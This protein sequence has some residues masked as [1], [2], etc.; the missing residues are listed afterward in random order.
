MSIPDPKVLLEHE[1]RALLTRLDAVQPLAL[2]ETMV[3]AANVS[4][5][6]QSAMERGLAD[7]SRHVRSMVHAFLGWLSG[8]QGQRASAAQAQ[9]RFC[10]LRLRFNAVLAHFD[11]FSDG[12]SQRSEHSIGVWLAGLDAAATDGL[13]LPPFLSPPPLLCYV[14]RGM[15]AAIRRARTR[16][17]GGATNPVAIIRVP[18]ER[19][20][21]S[22]IASSL[23]HEVGH[24]AAAL[25]GLVD[26]LRLV[27]KGLQRGPESADL[28]QIWERWISE[29]VADF[30]SVARV[31][32]TSTL[33]LMSVVSLPRAFVFRINLD[34]PHP[35]P[36]IRVKL[37]CAMGRLLF[38]H[39]Q[40]QRVERMWD[41]FYPIDA[42]DPRRQLFERLAASAPALA[43]LVVNHRP[44]SLRGASLGE[45]M[46]VIERQ[47]VR[48]QA[49]LAA[50]RRDVQRMKDTPPSLALAVIGQGRA[51]GTITPEEESRLVGSLLRLWA[52]RRLSRSTA[53]LSELR[54]ALAPEL[55]NR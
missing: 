14:D 40:W 49:H 33:G 8:P 50:W 39:P 44:R 51:D 31:G 34:D 17:P 19:M 41:A 36:W 21:G 6:A 12:L 28:W 16:L 23:F 24:Q 42:L 37:S 2:N 48:L 10:F 35:F 46:R 3:P 18:R 29:I 53:Q 32:V 5:A 25:L 15:G 1:A 9:Q 30:W 13:A 45:V 11:L 55:L 47:P 7:G 52:L 26:S 22:G 43:S 20:I 4:F 54:S 38:P 27:L